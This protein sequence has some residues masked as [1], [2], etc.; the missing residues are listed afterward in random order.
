MSAAPGPGPGPGPGSAP[1]PAPAPA[2]AAAH[3]PAPAPAAA[4]AAAPAAAMSSS[5]DDEQQDDQDVPDDEVEAASGAHR[6]CFAYDAA[7]APLA[8]DAWCVLCNCVRVGRVVEMEGAR[9]RPGGDLV[10]IRIE[11]LAL[12]VPLCIRSIRPPSISDD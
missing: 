3:A 7:P 10:C 12:C 9:A 2:H 5:D 6:T 8:A 4:A 11:R 1:A